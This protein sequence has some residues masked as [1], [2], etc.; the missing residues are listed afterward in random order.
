MEGQVDIFIS[1]LEVNEEIR[2]HKFPSSHLNKNSNETM[3][4]LT[5]QRTR[6]EQTGPKLTLQLLLMHLYRCRLFYI[7]TEVN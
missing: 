4:V 2:M 5:M 7:N 1:H 6:P 3:W